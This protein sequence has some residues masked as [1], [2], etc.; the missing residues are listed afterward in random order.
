M[1]LKHFWNH[2][3]SVCL[4]WRWCWNILNISPEGEECL[5]T[6]K[7]WCVVI[8]VT[9]RKALSVG[10]RNVL[11]SCSVTCLIQVYGKQLSYWRLSSPHAANTKTFQKPSNLP[12]AYLPASSGLF[13]SMSLEVHFFGGCNIIIHRTSSTLPPTPPKKKSLIGIHLIIHTPE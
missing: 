4:L 12:P 10:H 6:W 8:K 2:K 5:R 13:P 1:L 7:R 3:L 9:C 11:F